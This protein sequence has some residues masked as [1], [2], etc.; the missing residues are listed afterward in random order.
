MTETQKLATQLAFFLAN[1]GL[2]DSPGGA[3]WFSSD[4]NKRAE[5]WAASFAKAKE[6][7]ERDDWSWLWRPLDGD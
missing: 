1:E 7:A 2:I 6:Q 4:R 5:E 3:E